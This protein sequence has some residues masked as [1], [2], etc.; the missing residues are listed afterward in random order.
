MRFSPTVDNLMNLI[1]I[2][3]FFK[4]SS[5]IWIINND[6]EN[7]SQTLMTN[8]NVTLKTL[9]RMNLI[10][11][12]YIVYY[13][14]VFFAVQ[15]DR[16]LQIYSGKDR[17]CQFPGLWLVICYQSYCSFV[18]VTDHFIIFVPRI[19]SRI[20]LIMSGITG[21]IST[22]GKPTQEWKSKFLKIS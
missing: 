15:A 4:A 14:I 11:Q 16:A 13:K 12:V 19:C 5:I 1:I 2:L 20:L 10:L 7:Y 17:K 3:I 8:A 21:N 6:L 22:I 9:F 18:T